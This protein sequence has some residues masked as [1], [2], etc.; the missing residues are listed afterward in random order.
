MEDSMIYGGGVAGYEA[1]G[2]RRGLR[3]VL[4]RGRRRAIGRLGIDRA[5]S[6][7]RPARASQPPPT[8]ISN[9]P[10]PRY[11]SE[12]SGP[13]WSHWDGPRI[14]SRLEQRAI[15][16]GDIYI[17]LSSN[18]VAGRHT[19]LAS[20]PF[21]IPNQCALSNYSLV[22]LY[23][24]ILLTCTIKS[25]TLVEK[26]AI[27]G[28]AKKNSVDQIFQHRILTVAVVTHCRKESNCAKGLFWRQYKGGSYSVFK[29]LLY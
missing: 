20:S 10:T 8:L 29:R 22:P 17:D 11:L 21:Y 5:T 26:H 27:T 18:W 9:H 12:F 23:N 16:R 25:P 7:K 1:G 19:N 6:S 13:S 28:I 24:F 2:V 14:F 15:D 3:R 4:T